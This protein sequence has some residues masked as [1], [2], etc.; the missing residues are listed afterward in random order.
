MLRSIVGLVA[1]AFI[2]LLFGAPPWAALAFGLLLVLVDG[3]AQGRQAAVREEP[4]DYYA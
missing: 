4:E 2:L 1:T 3:L